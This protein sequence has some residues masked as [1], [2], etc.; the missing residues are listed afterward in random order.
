MGGLLVELVSW[1][2]VFFVNLPLGV[3]ALAGLWLRLPAAH[4]ERPERPLDASGAA[5][6]AGAT[7]ALMLT[8][9]GAGSAT[10]GI[11]RRSSA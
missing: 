11:R 3:A 7:S 9:S 5:F 2:W 8:A 6:T 1:R 4:T 10:R